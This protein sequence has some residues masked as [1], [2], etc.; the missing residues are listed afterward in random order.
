M[1]TKRTLGSLA[2]RAGIGAL[3]LTALGVGGGTVHA[4]NAPISHF[5]NGSFEQ[6]DIRDGSFQAFGN[7]TVF[8]S[9]WGT[10]TTYPGG[11]PIRCWRVTRGSVDVVDSG[12][13]AAY[14]GRQSVD[15]NS[16]SGGGSI[17]QDVIVTPSSTYRFE[18]RTSTNPDVPI[19]ARV[20]LDIGIRMYDAVGRT[21]G[22]DLT[23]IGFENTDTRRNMR[24]A[25]Q[26]I[27][28]PTGPN[29]RSVSVELSGGASSSAPWWGG[30]VVDHTA[31]YQV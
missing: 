12:Y 11:S 29:V 8:G 16:N 19:G 21:V 10:V 7:G 5:M 6:P 27:Q 15:L 18:V 20:S 23:T 28:F 25:R 24:W 2:R 26:S 31:L 17:R 13:W 30:P 4:E 22:S 1:T 3:V 14:S 9:C